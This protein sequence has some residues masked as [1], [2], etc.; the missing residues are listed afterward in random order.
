V[1]DHGLA[2]VEAACAE[3]LEAGIGKYPPAKPG[4]YMRLRKS[5]VFSWSFFAAFSIGQ[6]PLLR[7]SYVRLNNARRLSAFM[8]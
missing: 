1:L 7:T 4:A 2:A 6:L 8:A 3:A 5:R